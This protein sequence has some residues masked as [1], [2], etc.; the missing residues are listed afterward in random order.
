M[1]LSFVFSK[2][3]AL[4]PRA[5]ANEVGKIKPKKGHSVDSWIELF[6]CPLACCPSGAALPVLDWKKV[7]DQTED[8]E[9]WG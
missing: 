8:G 3:G 2:G 4:S 9:K 6:R 5:H 7:G 1:P